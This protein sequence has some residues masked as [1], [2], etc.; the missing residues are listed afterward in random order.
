MERPEWV[1]ATKKFTEPVLISRF[2]NSN[3]LSWIRYCLSETT[4]E[5]RCRSCKINYSD[6]FQHHSRFGLSIRLEFMVS[7]RFMRF[8]IDWDAL[9]KLETRACYKNVSGAT[10][11]WRPAVPCGST[12]HIQQNRLRADLELEAMQ[13]GSIDKNM[14]SMKQAAVR[15]N[16]V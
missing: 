2:F 14:A 16:L 8:P 5:E 3:L 7:S 9:R 12:K 13:I 6:S 4:L 1:A 11:T 15:H 10:T